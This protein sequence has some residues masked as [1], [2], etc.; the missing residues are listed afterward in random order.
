[1][2]RPFTVIAL[3]ALLSVSGTALAALV[4][5]TGHG[6]SYDPGIALA[7]ARADAVAKCSAQGGTPIAEVYNHLTRG[8][9]WLADSVWSCNVP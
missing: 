8:A 2:K 1:M 6:Q 3:A 9:L 4:Y 5:I 7:N